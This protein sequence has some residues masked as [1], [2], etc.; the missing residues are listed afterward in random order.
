MAS[1]KTVETAQAQAQVANARRGERAEIRRAERAERALMEKQ[2]ELEALQR[3]LAELREASGAK[4]TK[5]SKRKACAIGG[6]EDALEP[7][8]AL[9]G[10]YGSRCRSFYAYGEPQGRY[11]RLFGH[12][13]VPQVDAADFE[14]AMSRLSPPLVVGARREVLR[15]LAHPTHKDVAEKIYFPTDW[16]LGGDLK[17]LVEGSSMRAVR[18]DLIHVV[19]GYDVPKFDAAM[20]AMDMVRFEF[21]VRWCSKPDDPRE[22]YEEYTTE[23]VWVGDQSRVAVNLRALVRAAEAKA[24]AL[25]SPPCSPMYEPSAP[26]YGDA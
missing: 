14:E 5:L 4:R 13:N 16:E 9:E 3:E 2:A 11:G 25:A 15:G 26:C 6:D 21:D 18:G 1:T 24:A 22:P 19:T 8:E 20:G 7:D 12:D 23:R 10:P 17:D